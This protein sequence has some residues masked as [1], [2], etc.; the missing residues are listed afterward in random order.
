MS[1]REI[2][3]ALKQFRER[4]IYYRYRLV[5]FRC[6]KRKSFYSLLTLAQKN[7]RIGQ[8]TCRR[9][10]GGEVRWNILCVFAAPVIYLPLGMHEPVERNPTD[11]LLIRLKFNSNIYVLRNVFCPRRYVFCK[12]AFLK[13][14][15][16]KM[17]I[18][19]CLFMVV[20]APFSYRFFSILM[21]QFRDEAKGKQKIFSNNLNTA[22]FACYQQNV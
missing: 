1:R 5:R 22:Q 6:S 14:T 7:C 3:L 9:I 18:S 21:N 15:L 19:R 2:K 4:S 10:S 11:S 20:K 13:K 8:G 16:N 12:V 17:Q